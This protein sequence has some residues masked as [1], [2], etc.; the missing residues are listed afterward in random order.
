MYDAT[1][2]SNL[3]SVTISPTVANA[4]SL[5]IQVSYVG[6][7]D[8]ESGLKEVQ[9][10]YRKE[11]GGVW[12]NTGL[13][14]LTTESGTFN[15]APSV[16]EGTYYLMVVPVDRAGNTRPISGNGDGTVVYDNTPPVVGTVN[17]P[18][19]ASGAGISVGYTSASDVGGSGVSS[20][21]LWY[22]NGDSGAWTEYTITPLV[23]GG[24][25]VT[26]VSPGGNN[27]RYYLICVYVI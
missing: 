18:D 2:P 10:W 6:A 21:R 16:D 23:V 15:F 20:Y 8:G 25:N 1:R 19:Y 24:G 4:S 12:T 13:T 3:T 9:L 26:F 5:P 11:L 7:A 17:A 22:K 14:P 27:G